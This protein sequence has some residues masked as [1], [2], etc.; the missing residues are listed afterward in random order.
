[1]KLYSVIY[2]FLY[3]KVNVINGIIFKYY[4]GVFRMG[5]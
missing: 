1:M 3:L 4:V 2:V 5:F